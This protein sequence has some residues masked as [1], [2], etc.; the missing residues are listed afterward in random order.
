MTFPEAV[1]ITKLIRARLPPIHA[2]DVQYPAASACICVRL[3]LNQL[4]NEMRQTY[5]RHIHAKYFINER[6]SF[7]RIDKHSLF[8]NQTDKNR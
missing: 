4:K 8:A 7:T 2:Y 6:T 1:T 5:H 3:Y